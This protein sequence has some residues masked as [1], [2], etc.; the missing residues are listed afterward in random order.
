MTATQTAVPKGEQSSVV[1]FLT[2]ENVSGSEIHTKKCVC[3]VWHAE[4]YHKINCE[5][6]EENWALVVVQDK[7]FSYLA[8][9]DEKL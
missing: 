9:F 7:I 2:L 5:P 6:I 1:W 8:N 4:C 3:S